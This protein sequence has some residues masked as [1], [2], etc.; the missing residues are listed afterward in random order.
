[1]RVGKFLFGRTLQFM[2]NVRLRELYWRAP[3]ALSKLSEPLASVES[4][5][6]AQL[7]QLGLYGLFG[8]K[9]KG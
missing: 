6:S 5:P 1:M 8:S 2:F 9:G 3:E 7:R 4:S